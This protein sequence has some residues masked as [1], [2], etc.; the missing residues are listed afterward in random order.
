MTTPSNIYQP[1]M[2]MG[3]APTGSTNQYGVSYGSSKYASDTYAALTQD[4]WNTYVGS[5]VP[6]ENQ[7][8]GYANDPTQPL[9]SMQAASAD[10]NSA[11]NQQ[12]GNL[13]R[14]Q[15]GMG[16]TLNA[17]EQKAQASNFGLSKALA[18][19]GAQNTA[20]ALTTQRQQSILGAP[21]PITGG[22]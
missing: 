13:Q 10:V 22:V 18:D 6:I 8:I 4:Q 15:A 7:L 21:A 19:V 14:T 3:Q 20:A 2:G 16:I 12:Q 11:Y 9:K 5:F 1:P 17:D